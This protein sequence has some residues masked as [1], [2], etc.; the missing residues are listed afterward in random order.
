MKAGRS[1]MRRLVPVLIVAFLG[2]F[3]RWRG[4]EPAGK[5]VAAAASPSAMTDR[6]AAPPSSAPSH[7]LDLGPVTDAAHRDQ[8]TRVVSAFD[9]TGAPPH[10]VAQGGRRNGKRGMFVN[11]EGRL[12]R[13]PRGYWIESDVWP[14][15]GPRDAERLIF[16]RE[17]EVYWTVD[18]YESFVRLR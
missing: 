17:R 11:A 2:I 8:I 16:G 6:S 5:D 15:K 18:H 14:K 7:G 9:E 10:G 12:P 13:R 4:T 1:A 3:A